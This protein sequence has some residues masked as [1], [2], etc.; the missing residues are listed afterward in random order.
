MFVIFY[1]KQEFPLIDAPPFFFF[2]FSLAVTTCE[3]ENIKTLLSLKFNDYSIGVLRKKSF[4]NL[5]GKGI[6]TTDGSDWAHSRAMLRPN[7]ARSQVGDLATFETHINHMIQAIPTDGSTVDLQDLFFDLTLD[8]ATEFLFGESANTLVSGLKGGK[9]FGEAFTYCTTKLGFAIR[10]GMRGLIADKKY[11]RD[12]KIIHSFADQYV[13]TALQEYHAGELK[14]NDRYV[15]LHELVKQTQDP[16]ELRS[17]T[18]NILLAGRD[19]TASLL[20]DLWNVLS[21][22]PDLWQKL[23]AEIDRLDGRKPTFEEIKEMK[24]LCYCL[25]E[26]KL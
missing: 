6:F 5:F 21:K 20:S 22:R 12:Q 24:F 8:S 11:S 16:L 14:S 2:L 25:N 7:F 9:A 23:Q 10:A 13:Q 18:L 19:T 3:P 17:E 15:F 1:N 4:Q 26:C